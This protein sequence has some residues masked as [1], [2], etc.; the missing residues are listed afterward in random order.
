LSVHVLRISAALLAAAG[1]WV[2]PASAVSGRVVDPEGKPVAGARACIMVGEAWSAEGLCDETKAEGGYR[3]PTPR[4]PSLLR[5][6]ADGFL[7]STV[8]ADDRTE[9]IVLR[10]AASLLVRVLDAKTGQPIP[11]SEVHLVYANG[12]DKGPLP[13]NRAGVLV[14]ALPPGEAVLS[15]KAAGYAGGKGDTIT[16]EAGRKTEVELKLEPE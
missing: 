3:L 12:E 13:A 5:I 16:L 10:R 15:A 7:P 14:N 1:W 9:P 2:T 8:T 11:K 6:V 4:T